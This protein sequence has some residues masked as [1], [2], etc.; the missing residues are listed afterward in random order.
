MSNICRNSRKIL[1][2]TAILLL[3]LSLISYAS[4]KEI[5]VTPTEDLMREHGVLSR[6]LLIY[7]ESIHRLNN[8]EELKPEILHDTAI[9]VRQFIENYHEKSEENYVFPRFEKAGKQVELVRI[10]R[11]QHDAGRRLTDNILK[12]SNTASFQNPNDKEI[13]GNS[14]KQFIVMYRPHKAREDTILFPEFKKLIT[15]KEYKD[16]GD[17]LENKEEQLFGKNGFEKIVDKVACIEKSLGIYDLNKFT[18]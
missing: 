2:I 14:L 11:E 17:K 12:Y 3:S 13:L 1:I 15:E 16:L 5:E 9:I 7:E 8:N 4:S 6:V 10:L 18:P